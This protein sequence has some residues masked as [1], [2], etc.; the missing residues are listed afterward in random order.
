MSIKANFLIGGAPKCGTTSLAN[1]LRD[2]PQIFLSEIKEPFYF[3]DDL[4]RLREK[5]R[6]QTSEQ[7]AALF[8]GADDRCRAVGEGS[9]LYLFS[10]SA[11][12]NALAYNPAMKF[13][14]MVRHPVE[15]AHAF[16]MQMRFHEYEPLE[17][18]EA[19]W[20]DLPRRRLDPAV[21]PKRCLEPSMVDYDCIAA[22][23]TQLDR[24][25]TLIPPD[26]RLVLCF[27]DL[28]A[29]A[30]QVYRRTLGF[31]N[32]DDDRRG[33]FGKDNA[34]M[35]SRFPIVTRALRHHWVVSASLMTKRRLRGRWYRIARQTK[36]SLMFRRAERPT[37][38]AEFRRE[39][40][41]HFLSEIE[42]L[43]DLLKRDLSSWKRDPSGEPQNVL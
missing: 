16:H 8:A 19:A 17:S 36:H 1:Y 41:E 34:A 6:V 18:F 10:E 3:A 29:D 38:S 9:T 22:M 2:H 20:R 24:A 12:E 28:K 37:L 5:T 40:Q 13:V 35:K 25:M 43:E 32:V 14:F 31:L 4:P 15:V 30:G 11:I 42:L 21:L 23:G 26:Q 7:Y 39:L 27:D 33:S